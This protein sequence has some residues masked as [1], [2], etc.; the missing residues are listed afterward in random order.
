LDTDTLHEFGKHPDWNESF[1]FNFYDR[2][3]DVFAFMRIG[4]KP[5]RNEKSS[6]CFLMMPDGSLLG[7]KGENPADNTQLK[8]GDLRFEKVVPEKKWRLTFSGRVDKH[9]GK[10]ST[11][12]QASFELDFECL[13]QAFDYRQCVTGVKEKISEEIA[14]QHF[15]QFG[16]VTGRLA[17]GENEYSVT[18]LGERDHSWGVREWNAPKMWIWLTCQ[19]SESSALNVTKL[20]MDAGEVDAG[21]IHISGRNVPITKVNIE[22]RYD[23]SGNPRGLKMTVED[24]EGSMHD[25]TAEVMRPAVLPFPGRD[26]KSLSLLHENLAKYLMNSQVGF[27][28]AEYLIRTR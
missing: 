12:E 11:H 4:L 24:K 7:T 6:F 8:V 23:Q 15:E 25:V 3:I 9:A 2:K 27:G 19:F 16:K 14:S 28:V 5:N 1:Y 20:V 22:T 21:F 26:G 17:L 10:M 13:N 18:G